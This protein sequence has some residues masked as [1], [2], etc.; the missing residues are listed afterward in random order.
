[1]RSSVSSL[2]GIILLSVI[3]VEHSGQAGRWVTPWTEDYDSVAGMRCTLTDRQEPP[4]TPLA[5]V[6]ALDLLKPSGG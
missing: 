3:C 2:R 4:R 6:G 5:S 1:M